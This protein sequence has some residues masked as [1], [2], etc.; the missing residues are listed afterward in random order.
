MYCTT[1][2]TF[3][4][5]Y[6]CRFGVLP[7]FLSQNSGSTPTSVTH[8]S[9]LCLPNPTSVQTHLLQLLMNWHMTV[10]RHAGAKQEDDR[11]FE[12]RQG[13]CNEPYCNQY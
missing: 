2:E 11:D 5:S 3:Y 9:A 6:I 10:I 8:Y 7:P 12:K 1:A 13:I 4:R